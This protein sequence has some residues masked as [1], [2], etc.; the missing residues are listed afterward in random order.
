VIDLSSRGFTATWR[1]E[2]PD[3][4]LAAIT[5]FRF[6]YRPD[7]CP[8]GSSDPRPCH[9][10]A[11]WKTLHL[12]PGARSQRIPGATHDSYWEIEIIPESE[13]GDGG[14]NGFTGYFA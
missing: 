14:R 12:G 13:A 2:R 5:G 1:V 8:A 9:H 6:R 7:L 3:P 11:R 4:G 10:R